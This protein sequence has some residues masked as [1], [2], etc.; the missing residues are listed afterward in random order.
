MSVRAR[1]NISAS[2]LR[3]ATFRK[4]HRDLPPGMYL[5]FETA[6]GLAAVEGR[7]VLATVTLAELAQALGA[8]PVSML[9]TDE[10]VALMATYDTL[11]RI[12]RSAAAVVS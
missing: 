9:E 5:R 3:K 1:K 7:E 2:G 10:Y 11:N 6:S 4:G 12:A 8:V